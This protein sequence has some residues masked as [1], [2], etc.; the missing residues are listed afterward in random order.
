MK[1][2][3]LV[4]EIRE[5]RKRISQAYGHN[6]QRLVEHYQELEKH[7]PGRILP[8]KGRPPAKPPTRRKNSRAG[9]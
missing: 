6:A 3:V 5:V 9:R 8:D 1:K 2:D 4:E 7:Y